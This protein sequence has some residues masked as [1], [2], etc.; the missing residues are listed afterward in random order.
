MGFEWEPLV[1][2]VWRG[3]YA[4]STGIASNTYAIRLAD[5]SVAVL[6]PPSA[7]TEEVFA[8]TEALGP[9]RALVAQNTGH[10]LGQARWQARYPAATPYA[11]EIAAP[12]LAKAKVGLRPFRP[13]AE[14][15]ARLPAGAQLVDVPGARSGMTMLSYAAGDERLLFLDEILTNSPTLPG[16]A[17]IRLVF[18]L[19]RSGPGLARNRLW[20]TVFASDRRQVARAVIAEWDARPPSVVALSHGDPIRTDRLSAARAL[21]DGMAT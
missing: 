17:I 18:W 6:S 5:G 21:I 14:L 2:G 4:T 1:V 19:A 15:A 12:K 20:S 16:P 11:P 7:P 13:L 9:V 8:A 10:D 3:T